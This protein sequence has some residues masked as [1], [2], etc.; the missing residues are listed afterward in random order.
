MRKLFLGMATLAI[1]FTSCDDD[2]TTITSSQDIDMSD[3]TVYTTEAELTAKT[4]DGKND[5]KS[6]YTMNVLNRKLQENPG[7]EQKM[8]AIEYQTRK[9]IASKKPDGAGN[10]GGGGNGET[11]V[12]VLPIA[13]NLGIINIPVYVHIVYPDA[14]A[15]TD[16]QV[17]TQMATL[18]TDFR[19]PNTDLLPSG[20]TFANDATDS[21]FSFSLAGVFRYNDPTNLFLGN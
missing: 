16:N 19:N 20:T 7:L 4:A 18:N 21:G 15:V 11:D 13:D 9:F 5:K 2:K 6:C 10:G 14:T 12:D 3:F 17:T 8:Y 1:V